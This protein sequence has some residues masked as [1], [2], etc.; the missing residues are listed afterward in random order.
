[1]SDEEPSGGAGCGSLE[2][3]GESTTPAEPSKCTFDHPSPWQE[4][5]AFD[6]S[7]ALDDLDRPG[8]AMGERP[9]QLIAAVDA[10]GK[11]MAQLGELGTQMLQQRDGTVDILHIG[12]V[13]AH[14]E[15]KA[16]GIG[17]DV[18]LASM[19]AFAGVEAA[20]PAAFGRRRSL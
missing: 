17:D 5:E 13:N 11:D 1:M 2:V 16:V 8:P 19:E 12:R 20:R 10:I 3:L 7:W 9:T 6:A 18:A 14:G 15:Q 4:L